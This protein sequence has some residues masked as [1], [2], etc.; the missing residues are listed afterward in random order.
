MLWCAVLFFSFFFSSRRRHTSC[1]LVTGVQTCAL[2]IL[3]VVKLGEE[4]GNG[5]FVGPVAYE[6]DSIS[7]LDR[8][9]FGP[10]LHV[11]RYT[12][13]DLEAVVD[14]INATGYGLTLGRSEA[15]R[16]GKECVSTCR[17]RWSPCP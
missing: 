11:V 12:A 8:E 15:R 9:N 6:I 17:S 7:V 10:I 4:T 13:A 14:A 2:P 5:H 3:C 16:V 1:A